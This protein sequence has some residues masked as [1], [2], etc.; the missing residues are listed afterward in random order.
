MK[1]F[2]AVAMGNTLAIASAVLHPLFHLWGWYAPRSYEMLFSEFVIG[3]QLKVEESFYPHF[4]FF[5]IVEIIILWFVGF[6]TA[7]LYNR[8]AKG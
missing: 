5:Y 1:K 6:V 4:F 3:L 8:L 2:D 7:S